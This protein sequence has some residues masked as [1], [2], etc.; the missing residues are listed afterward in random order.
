MIAPWNTMPITLAFKA[1]ERKSFRDIHC[2]ECGWPFVTVTDKVVS[3]IDGAGPIND[4]YPDNKTII[5]VRCK[6]CKQY[7][8]L[9]VLAFA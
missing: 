6:N 1:M 9:D 2:L 7:F 4:I 8:R 5:E 3:I